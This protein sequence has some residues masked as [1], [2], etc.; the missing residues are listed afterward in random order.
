M[1]ATGFTRATLV[2]CP[3]QRGRFEADGLSGQ[4]ATTHGCNAKVFAGERA[5]GPDRTADEAI[6]RALPANRRA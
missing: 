3:A 5:L 6:C 2:M 1:P 4:S